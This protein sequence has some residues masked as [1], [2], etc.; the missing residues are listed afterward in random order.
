M[1]F[2]M[3]ILYL[4]VCYMALDGLA[5]RNFINGLSA[6]VGPAH[7]YFP[8]LL[9]AASVFLAIFGL[10]RL[11]SDGRLRMYAPLTK[12]AVFFV[13]CYFMFYVVKLIGG[14]FEGVPAES[15]VRR[16]AIDTQCVYLFIPLFYLKQEKTLKQLL[17]FVVPVT[18]LFPLAQPFLYGS[19]DQVMFLEGQGTLRLGFGNGNLLLMLGVLAFFV[20]ERKM[21]MSALPMAGIVMLG[22]RSAFV[23]LALCV[24]VLAFQKKKS[25]KYIFLMGIVGALLVAALVIIQTTTSVPILGKAAERL[26][27]TF[28]NTGTTKARIG[29]IP[30]SLGEFEKRPFVGFSYRDLYAL[31]NR[32]DAFSFNMLHPHN[33]ALATLLYSGL[34][35]TLLLVVTIGL[36]MVAALRIGRE[37]TTKEQGM[38]LCSTVLFFVVFGLMNT[39]FLSEGYLFW[40][41]A[42]VSL[43]YL[44][45]AHYNKY[46]KRRISPLPELQTATRPG[47]F[48]PISVTG[49]SLGGHLAVM[50]S[51][52]APAR[53]AQSTLITPPASQCSAPAS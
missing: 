20:W 47:R 27:Q 19:A 22:Q 46:Q 51:R 7:I 28:E 31:Q 32:N 52:L 53:S 38:Y 25:V 18:L 41:L 8:D 45:Q 49:H 44:N 23:S 3:L 21:W 39:S 35:G 48:R 12:A 11:L 29:M 24:I 36:A 17:S 42:G 33:E 2:P 10:F 13:I 4:Q 37:P 14:Y 40:I 9:Y 6:S 1:R 34:I 43:W 30:L 16:F 15:L 50:L 5:S 26:S